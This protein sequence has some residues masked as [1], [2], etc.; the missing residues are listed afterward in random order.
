MFFF[1][2]ARGCVV[3][4]EKRDIGRKG[5]RGRGIQN[6]PLKILFKLIID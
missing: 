2:I 4:V 5:G 6:F 1:L 3:F